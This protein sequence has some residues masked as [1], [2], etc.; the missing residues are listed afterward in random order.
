MISA[1]RASTNPRLLGNLLLHYVTPVMAVADWLLLDRDRPARWTAP[2]AW[3]A[4]PV[5][6]GIFIVLRARTLPEGMTRR[7]VYPYLNLDRIGWDGFAL[8]GGALLASFAVAG[9]ALVWLYRL[10]AAYRSGRHG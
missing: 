2:V 7:Y 3:L 5:S 8:V 4:F 6:Y 1:W 9:Y 10:V